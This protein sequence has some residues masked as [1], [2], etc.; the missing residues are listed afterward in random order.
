MARAD[1]FEK[2]KKTKGEKLVP[3]IPADRSP[4]S[5]VNRPRIEREHLPRKYNFGL[6]E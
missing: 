3:K 6:K 4:G 1:A 2:K 5:G